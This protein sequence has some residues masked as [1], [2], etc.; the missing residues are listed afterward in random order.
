MGIFEEEYPSLSSYFRAIILFGR[1]SASY[2]FSLAQSLIELASQQ[3]NTFFPLEELSIP[4]SKHMIEHLKLT[5]KQTTARSSKFLDGCRN[6]IRGIL[7]YQQM[8]QLTKK[9]AFEVVLDAFHQVNGKTIPIQFFEVVHKNR[10]RGIILTDHVYQLFESDNAINFPYEI[11]ARWRLVETAWSLNIAP[12]LLVMN[13]DH[14]SGEFYINK[15][16]K[17]KNVTSSRDALNGYQKGK[18]FYCFNDIS[19]EPGSEIL[20]DVD[21]FFPHI[22]QAH[23]DIDLNGVWNLVLA[24]P[25]CNRGENGKFAN[26]PA[27]KYLD[28]LHKRN[29]FFIE[30]HHPL[31]ETLINQTGETNKQRIDF[32]RNINKRALDIITTTWKSEIEF[33]PSF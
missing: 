17:R 26:I 4:F 15:D 19:I 6:Y 9:H 33:E 31:R 24:C 32:L 12:S 11:E 27:S 1:N 23:L 30:S 2:K 20:A 16:N 14:H 22:L 13:Y 8:L 25:S 3:E 10:K 5:D 29:S 28:R 18:C 21:H 7:P